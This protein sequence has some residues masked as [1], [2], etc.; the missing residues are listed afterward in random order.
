MEQD[1]K[2]HNFT[3]E[4]SETL[5]KD[6]YEKKNKNGYVEW[7]WKNEFPDYLI[8]LYERSNLHNSIIKLKSNMIGGNGFVPANYK[9]DTIR[10]IKNAYNNDG[11]D[12][13]SILEATAFDFAIH[14]CFAWQIRWSKDRNK[15]SDIGYI[16]VRNIRIIPPENKGEK[17]SYV[18]CSNWKNWKKELDTAVTYP[19]FD[20]TNREVA[21][22]IYF[23]SGQNNMSSFYPKPDYFS[24]LMPMETNFHINEFHL[25]NI[26]RQFA[27]SVMIIQRKIPQ[28][29]EERNRV[30]ARME[31]KWKGSRKY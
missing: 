31:E 3:L 29:I 4:A 21:T 16:P 25:S 28:S 12:L 18:I 7:G 22:Q 26:T 9:Q 13:E 14:N 17:E 11:M 6:Y 19:A 24:G 2:Y 23:Y 30:I 20:P 27:P 8:G 5:L 1:K 15:I 10:F